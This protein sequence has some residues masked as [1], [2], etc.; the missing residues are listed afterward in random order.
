[1]WTAVLLKC[2]S[3]GW[4][5]KMAQSFYMPIT[6]SNIN[7]F[8]ELFHWWNQQKICCNINTKDPTTPHRCRYTT[9]CNVKHRTQASDD[10]DQFHYQRWLS[11]T[12]DVWRVA[13]VALRGNSDVKRGQTPET[14]DE[15]KARNMR[16]SSRPRPIVQSRGQDRGQNLSSR[17]LWPREL[18]IS[19]WKAGF[20]VRRAGQVDGW[21]SLSVFSDELHRPR[22][23][24]ARHSALDDW[25][26]KSLHVHYL[27]ERSSICFFSG[28]NP[29]IGQN[30]L[31]Y[32]T[33]L[34][35]PLTKR[36]HFV[37]FVPA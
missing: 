23:H 19:G 33:Q 37:M 14:E 6:S 31:S 25:L 9:L 28:H 29:P 26:S 11:L 4:A 8:S 3:T 35:S 32:M 30:L 21:W 2:P 1:M 10:N 24:T 22:P 34:P 27:N 20:T 5:K 36:K 16:P 15:A 17:P 7:R 12:C 18:N 13:C